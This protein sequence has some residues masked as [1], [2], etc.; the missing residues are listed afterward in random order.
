MQG[1]T[2]VYIRTQTIAHRHLTNRRYFDCG[3]NPNTPNL[4]PIPGY[5]RCRFWDLWSISETSTKKHVLTSLSDRSTQRLLAHPKLFWWQENSE[6]FILSHIPGKFGIFILY[7]WGKPSHHS[8]WLCYESYSYQ[9]SKHRRN[10][11]TFWKYI[12][13]RSSCLQPRP[14][15]ELPCW[16][17]NKHCYYTIPTRTWDI[18]S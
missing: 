8:L 5:R 16:T 3:E 12:N 18:K 2:R 13:W 7:L 6:Y 17:L 10:L 11:L 15:F 4:S 9:Y 1:F 14:S